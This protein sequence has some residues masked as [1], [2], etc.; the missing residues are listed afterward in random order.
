MKWH[1]GCSGFHYTD[2]KDIFYPAD[3]PENKWFHFYHTKFHTLELNASFYKFPTTDSMLK[4]HKKSPKHFTFSVKAPRIITHFHKLQNCDKYLL[5]FYTACR[6]GLKEKLGPVLFQFP[7]NFVYSEENLQH[8]VK[9]L[10]KSFVNV[11]EFRH[12]SWWDKKVYEVLKKH[13]IIFCSVN[14]P[15]LPDDIVV[16][17]HTVYYR[18]HGVPKLY[19]SE[20]EHGTLA[21]IA[22]LILHASKVKTAYC[23]FNNTATAGAIFNAVW[24]ENYSALRR[25]IKYLSH[26]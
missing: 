3:L 11:V 24:L 21:K 25:N 7:S 22:D 8:I 15:G 17:E 9:T 23:F 6:D 12:V 18:L 20:Y 1:V 26:N 5:D 16:M 4:W 2:W 14:F 10:D 19:H 13:S